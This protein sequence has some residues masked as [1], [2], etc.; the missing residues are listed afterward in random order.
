VLRV[1]LSDTQ[2]QV[3]IGATETSELAAVPR[4][5]DATRQII[6][7]LVANYKQSVKMLRDQLI[8]ALE[9]NDLTTLARLAASGQQMNARANT[10]ATELGARVCTENPLPSR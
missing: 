2:A 5:S 4:P 8:P 10:L 1:W 7:S 3:R 6:A 9:R